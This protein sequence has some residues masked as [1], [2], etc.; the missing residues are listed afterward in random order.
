MRSLKLKYK[1]AVFLCIQ[2]IENNIKEELKAESIAKEMGYS[3]YHFSRIFKE[4]M[5]ISL[6]EYVKDRRL[7]RAAE[8][9][10]SGKRILDVAIE[11][12]YQTHSGFTK[13]FRKKYGFAPAFNQDGD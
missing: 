13:A 3:V 4:E 12:G 10:M 8:D 11:Y 9:I 7:L 2:Y 1:E 5:G 6:M